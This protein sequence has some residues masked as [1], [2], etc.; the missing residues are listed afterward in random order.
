MFLCITL[1]TSSGI[2]IGTMSMVGLVVVQWWLQ[3]VQYSYQGLAD[4]DNAVLELSTDLDWSWTIVLLMWF[5]FQAID[6]QERVFVLVCVTGQTC[7]TSVI[8]CCCF[9]F[10]VLFLF[11]WCNDGVGWVVVP[12][13]A[14]SNVSAAFVVLEEVDRPQTLNHSVEMGPAHICHSHLIDFVVVYFS[15][16]FVIIFVRKCAAI[17]QNTS[18][19]GCYCYC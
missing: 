19:T 12:A 13:S 10:F 17:E 14:G 15:L 5:H 11:F 6:V 7:K 8:F 2:S 16:C 4:H 18:Q 3:T 1:E 9:C